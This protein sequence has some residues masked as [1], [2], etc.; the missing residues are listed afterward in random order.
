MKIQPPPIGGA[1]MVL[2]NSNANFLGYLLSI[3]FVASMTISLLERQ[4]EGFEDS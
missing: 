3:I 1:S 4:K 2:E